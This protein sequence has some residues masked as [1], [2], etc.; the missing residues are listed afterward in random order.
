MYISI[1]FQ[2][3]YTWVL[4]PFV[5][6]ESKKFLVSLCC[7]SLYFKDCNILNVNLLLKSS[8]LIYPGEFQHC[9]HLITKRTYQIFTR[10]GQK[11]AKYLINNSA[12]ILVWKT[13]FNKYRYSKSVNN[14]FQLTSYR[15]TYKGIC[16]QHSQPTKWKSS[17]IIGLF[18][19]QY[20]IM[21]L[22]LTG[23]INLRIYFED[24]FANKIRN[25]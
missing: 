20:T 11:V 3:G 16:I 14:K 18:N 13:N 5:F 12:N 21:L 25:K 22:I 10:L 19:I 23:Q 6:D 2:G 24:I 7:T 1:L 15:H 9:R 17:D 8:T 4:T